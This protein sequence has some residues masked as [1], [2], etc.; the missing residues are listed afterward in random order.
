MTLTERATVLQDLLRV[1]PKIEVSLEDCK[2]LILSHFV[3][4]LV[5]KT[6]A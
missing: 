4:S 3:E 2:D 1:D 5:D 6:P